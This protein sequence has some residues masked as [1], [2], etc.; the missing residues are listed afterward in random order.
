MSQINFPKFESRRPETLSIMNIKFA[1]L[2]MFSRKRQ[3]EKLK[4]LIKKFKVVQDVNLTKL[5]LKWEKGHRVAL[6]NLKIVQSPQSSFLVAINCP[7]VY[8]ASWISKPW[9]TKAMSTA[10]KPSLQSFLRNR[11][12][13][14][15]RYE[16]KSIEYTMLVQIKFMIINTPNSNLLS[17]TQNLL[18]LTNFCKNHKATYITL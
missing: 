6:S 5:W 8:G 13:A 4:V 16:C 11:L 18:S 15:T 3:L 2:K 1:P 17:K 7:P 14:K 9:A 10:K 12:E